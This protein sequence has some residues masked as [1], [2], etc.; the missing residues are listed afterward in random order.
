MRL[1]RGHV[2]R[3]RPQPQF[4]TR[5]ASARNLSRGRQD[6]KRTLLNLTSWP[7]EQVDGLRIILKGGT[8]LPPGEQ[9]FTITRSLP[10]GHV[11]AV[12]ATIR[13]AG[14]DRILA[15]ENNRPCRLVLAMI[16]SRA[17]LSYPDG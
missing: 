9:P 2:H 11:A 5:R 4:A 10:H 16:I 8:A 3:G 7:A 6:Q 14:L 12:L 13:D 15:P 17:Q 1:T